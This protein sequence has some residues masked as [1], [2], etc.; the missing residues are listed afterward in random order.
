MANG[1]A[2][3]GSRE[4]VPVARSHCAVTVFGVSVCGSPKYSFPQQGSRPVRFRR[5]RS[6]HEAP[7]QRA[8]EEVTQSSGKQHLSQRPTRS[9]SPA[10]T[11]SLHTHMTHSVAADPHLRTA[12]VPSLQPVLYVLRRVRPRAERPPPPHPT[13]PLPA[14]PRLH[15][16]GLRQGTAGHRIHSMQ[17]TIYRHMFSPS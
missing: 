1:Q 8:S 2:R 3:T 14:R 7:I 12:C 6:H 17:H 15:S 11:H 4:S 16:Q 9:V 13:A 5:Q 10:P